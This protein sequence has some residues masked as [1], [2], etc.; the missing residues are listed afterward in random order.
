MGYLYLLLVFAILKT[1]YRNRTVR[2]RVGEWLV[3]RR[4]DKLDSTRYRVISNLLIR[5]A[6]GQTSQIDHV[7]ISCYGV[8]V[9]EVKNYQGYIFGKDSDLYWTVVL[10]KHSRHKMYNPIRQ[11]D[12]HVKALK[13]VLQDSPG[14]LFRPIVVFTRSATLKVNTIGDVIYFAV[15][16]VHQVFRP[17]AAQHGRN[18][19]HP[20]SAVCRQC[21]GQAG[22]ERTCSPREK[23][24]P[25]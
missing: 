2:G 8:F 16:S 15:E 17:S 3:D 7:V 6:D 4:L 21:E 1:A 5:G 10:N 11:N 19:C 24:V 9:I 13:A 22:T 12:G 25:P 20:Q 18:G 14:H 23:I